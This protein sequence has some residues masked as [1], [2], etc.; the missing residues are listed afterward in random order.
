[1][2]NALLWPQIQKHFNDEF[3]PSLKSLWAIGF[4]HCPQVA[5]HPHGVLSLGHY[6]VISVIPACLE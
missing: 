3:Q 4:K 1:M 2:I 5:V 6:L